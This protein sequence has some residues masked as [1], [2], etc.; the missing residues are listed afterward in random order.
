MRNNVFEQT[1]MKLVCAYANPKLYLSRFLTNFVPG[2]KT[3]HSLHVSELLTNKITAVVNTPLFSRTSDGQRAAQ[4]QFDVHSSVVN[5]WLR[6]H[7]L[8][9]C[10]VLK[11]YV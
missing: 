7:V 2:P 1:P 8:V 4:Q 9:L 10:C 6:L 11:I 5:H 3:S